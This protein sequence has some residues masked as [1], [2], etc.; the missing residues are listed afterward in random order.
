MKLR[1]QGIK[2]SKGRIDF[3]DNFIQPNYSANLTRI[4]GTM[5]LDELI[6]SERVASVSKVNRPLI[7]A[8]TA[9]KYKAIYDQMKFMF[10]LDDG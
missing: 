6:R 5:T 7:Y 1:W 4:E 10:S 3:T 2:L 8:D 9:E